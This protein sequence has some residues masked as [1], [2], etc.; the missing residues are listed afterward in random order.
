LKKILS[1]FLCLCIT[2]GI[3]SVA[4]SAANEPYLDKDT[5]IVMVPG[6]SMNT[7]YVYDKSGNKISDS[8]L[9]YDLQA[10]KVTIP[11]LIF[12]FVMT[13]FLNKDTGLSKAVAGSVCKALPGFDNES[14][15]TKVALYDKPLSEYAVSDY[16][17]FSQYVDLSS[18]GEMLKQT[19]LYNYDDFGSIKTAADGLNDYINNVVLPQGYSKIVLCPISLGG[20]V[21]Q[22]YFDLYPAS[23]SLMKKVVF[24]VAALDGTDAIGELLTKD[25]TII[26]SSKSVANVICKYAKVSDNMQP[27]VRTLIGIFVTDR[28]INTI[29]DSLMF[30]VN[31]S[32]ATTTLWSLC[33]TSFY[34]QARSNYLM[35]SKD[36]AKRAEIDR[37]MQARANMSANLNDIEQNGGKV[38]VL[39]GYGMPLDQFCDNAWLKSSEN[40]SS[41]TIVPTYSTSIGATVAQLGQTLPDNYK[42]ANRVCTD[43]SHNHRSSDNQVDASTCLYPETTWFFYGVSHAGF[44]KNAMA[45]ALVKSLVSENGVKNVYDNENWPQFN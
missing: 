40:V 37:F 22:E 9:T 20:C 5:A 4:V 29:V 8:K 31:D 27:L 16:H 19:Y 14:Y 2:F 1:V 11:K 42:P 21:A 41:D 7:V 18:M 33:P 36:D 28:N 6:L 25:L 34:S 35:R 32:V 15:T 45:L 10:L 43:S 44:G 13:S 26:D 3:L 38:Y 39:S 12:S 23:H 17:A 24:M 30:G